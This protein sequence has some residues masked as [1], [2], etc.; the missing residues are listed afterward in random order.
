MFSA[1]VHQRSSCYAGV[2]GGTPILPSGH[3]SENDGDQNV[4]E[5]GVKRPQDLVAS[6]ALSEGVG[7]S[8]CSVN[9]SSEGGEDLLECGW[10]RVIAL[11]LVNVE[12]LLA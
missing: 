2:F 11:S 1:C 7:S 5:A 6:L 4:S 3:Q 8:A 12:G 10:G 9:L